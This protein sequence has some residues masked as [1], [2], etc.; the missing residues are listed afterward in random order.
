MTGIGHVV[1][2]F[3]WYPRDTDSKLHAIRD[4]PENDDRFVYFASRCLIRQVKSWADFV[5]K[6]EL[7]PFSDCLTRQSHRFSDARRLLGSSK[8]DV[9]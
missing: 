1:D 2:E 7:S 3:A 6:A 9:S 8:S 4:T 5:W